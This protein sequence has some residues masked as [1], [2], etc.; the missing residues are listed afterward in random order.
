MRFSDAGAMTHQSTGHRI[1]VERIDRRHFMP[2][3]QL[4]NLSAPGEEEVIA[5]DHERPFTLS[6]ERD[7]GRIQLAL[8]VGLDDQ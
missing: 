6:V 7:K 5:A 1:L 3:G 2:C 4:D 8:R